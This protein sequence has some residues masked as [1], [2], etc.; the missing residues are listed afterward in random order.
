MFIS[1]KG[2]YQMEND[3]DRTAIDVNAVFFYQFV[4]AKAT[5]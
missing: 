1:K 2:I 5:V 4:E 3:L